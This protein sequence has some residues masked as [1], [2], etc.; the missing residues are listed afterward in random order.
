MSTLQT[1]LV[2]S[3]PAGII[4]RHRWLGWDLWEPAFRLLIVLVGVMLLVWS[5]RS[6]ALFPVLLGGI[7]HSAGNRFLRLILSASSVIYLGSLLWRTGLWFCYRPADSL[8]VG[9]WPAVTVLLPAYNE[10]ETIQPTITAIA[11]S[12]YPAGRLKIIA[13]DDGSVDDTYAH[14]CRARERYPELME[15]IRF[16]RNCGKRQALYHGFQRVRTPFVVTIDSDTCIEPQAIRELLTPLILDPGISAATGRIRILNRNASLWTRILDTNF[17]MAF[18]FTRAI[19]STFH[20]VF[21]TSGA[22]SAYRTATLRRVLEPWLH[23][24]F[25][26]R[27]CTYGEDRSLANFILRLG[28]GTVF[29]R[30]AV[31]HTLIP[32]TCG[33]ILKM[34]TRWARSNIRESLVFSGL[35]FNPNRRGN[36]F[37][38]FL[39]FVSTA[40]LLLL[41]LLWIYGLLLFGMADGAFLQRALASTILCGFLYMLYFIRIE[42]VKQVPYVLAF[43]LFCSPLLVGIFTVAGLTLSTRRWSTR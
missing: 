8:R 7:S 27:P 2:P 9:E 34:L 17:A 1:E 3:L 23:Q 30:T 6:G 19:E 33:R 22:F 32:E 28:C 26:G 29:Q 31:A 15:V 35:M 21:C 16:E 37:L 40:V 25:L 20:S 10:G 11:A 4:G 36:Y 39:E 14:L 42:G 41:H 18:D 5:L 13:V 12:D 38:P 43:C 24:T